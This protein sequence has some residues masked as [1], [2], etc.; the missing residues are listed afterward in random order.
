[1]SRTKTKYDYGMLD[2]AISAAVAAGCHSIGMISSER[3]VS[4]ELDAIHR[5]MMR[6]WKDECAKE[7]PS[8][9]A[10][11]P[12][13]E[14]FRIID[15]RL[16]TLRKSGKIVYTKGKWQKADKPAE[17]IPPVDQANAPDADCFRVGD[18]WQSPRG[19]RYLVEKR[20]GNT[21]TLRNGGKVLRKPYD[22]IQP[23]GQVWTRESWGGNQQ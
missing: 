4:V 8:W 2:H 20:N 23:N 17:E 10:P 11:S 12:E 15:R 19:F 21:V 22:H 7:T 14:P 9:R 5:Q 16:Q 13:P 3:M 18:W 1:M 6:A